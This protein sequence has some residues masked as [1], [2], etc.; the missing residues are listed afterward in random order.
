MS[1]LAKFASQ[2][3][4]LRLSILALLTR[5][6]CYEDHEDD[7]T[8][9]RTT[10]AV[11]V[12]MRAIDEHPFVPPSEDMDPEDVPTPDDSAAFLLIEGMPMSFDKLERSIKAYISTPKA[13]ESTEG[14]SFQ[15]LT[16]VE[17]AITDSSPADADG[18]VIEGSH[19]SSIL[20]D[21]KKNKEKRRWIQLLLFMPFL[22]LPRLDESSD[23]QH[24]LI[25]LKARQSML[26]VV[27][28]MF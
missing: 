12:L 4:S 6:L 15:T 2:V 21:D 14:L 19:A 8:C 18:E 10:V 17:D 22:N 5:S 11:N 16:V 3:P 13:M 20:L 23:L 25:L 24:Q 26:F 1:A 9:D 28:N 27:S 7:E